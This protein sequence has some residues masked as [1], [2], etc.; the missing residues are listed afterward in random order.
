MPSCQCWEIYRSQSC[1][2]CDGRNPR[3]GVLT[4]TPSNE[5]RERLLVCRFAW[6]RKWSQVRTFLWLGQSSACH[7]KVTRVDELSRAE[8]LQN[9][10][11][12]ATRVIACIVWSMDPICWA[13]WSLTTITPHC[14]A[15]ALLLD[16]CS[17]DQQ[18]ICW[19][20][21]WRIWLTLLIIWDWAH[22]EIV[23]PGHHWSL[24]LMMIHHLI[25]LS[26]WLMITWTK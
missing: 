13:L 26:S 15:P 20:G 21:C 11:E 4:S 23:C 1:Q 24:S 10:Q 17:P 8:Y 6:N 18:N 5:R 9:K 12:T 25:T 3:P 7:N 16:H 22:H 19:C 14:P 2:N